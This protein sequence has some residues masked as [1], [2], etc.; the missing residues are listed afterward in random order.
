L[1]KALSTFLQLVFWDNIVA[2]RRWNASPD[3]P[4]ILLENRLPIILKA[5]AESSL[6]N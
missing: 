4:R 2:T 3:G 1:F 5:S 6:F